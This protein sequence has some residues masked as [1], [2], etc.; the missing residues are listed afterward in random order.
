MKIRSHIRRFSA[1]AIAVLA[2][3]LIGVVTAPVASASTSAAGN[4][5]TLAAANVGKTA[6]TCADTP[7]YNTLG[8]SEFTNGVV[9][10]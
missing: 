4:A 9:C 6:G 3:S 7:T 2:L 5:A 10:D 1:A 8:G